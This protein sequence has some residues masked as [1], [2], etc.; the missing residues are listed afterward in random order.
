[1]NPAKLISK[2]PFL[3]PVA[4]KFWKLHNI[5][6]FESIEKQAR[7]HTG[8]TVTKGPFRGMIY[9]EL[10]HGNI[11]ASTTPKLFGIYEQELYPSIEELLNKHHYNRVI[12]IGAAEG[13]YA[14]GLAL[15]QANINVI[16]F[17]ADQ[18]LQSDLRAVASINGVLDRI[19]VKGFCDAAS[20]SKLSREDRTLI[21]CDCEGGEVDL[22]RKEIL[23]NL[24]DTDLIIECHDMIVP[25]CTDVVIGNLS[26]THDY[27]LIT[28]NERTLSDIPSTALHSLVGSA[29]EIEWSIREHRHYR[30]NWIV[31]SQKN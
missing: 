2:I 16:A 29:E 7:S 10:A 8:N 18:Q 6:I 24:G 4:R 12:V 22:I 19:E 13:Y 11:H 27:E 21:I 5:L 25:N 9:P 28:S 14:V 31:A 30:M 26:S 3:R 15:K 1:M 17:E 20:L 23:S